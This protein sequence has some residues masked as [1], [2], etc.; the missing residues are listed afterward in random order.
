V[1]KSAIKKYGKEN[2][3]ISIV[4]ECD[5]IEEMNLKEEIYIKLFNS[6]VP[7]GYNLISGGNNRLASEETKRKMSISQKGIKNH[8]QM[9]IEKICLLLI[10]ET[11]TLK[12]LEERC[13]NLDL[14][15]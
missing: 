10:W 5:S 11:G 4:C 13:L 14:K 6:M 2:F 12:K 9:S 8:N 7:N 3:E 1:L 15:E